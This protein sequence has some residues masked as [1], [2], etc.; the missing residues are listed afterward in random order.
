LPTKFATA[1]RAALKEFHMRSTQ[2]RTLTAM[3]GQSLHKHHL[4]TEKASS[5]DKQCL[6][7]LATEPRRLETAQETWFTRSEQ[8]KQLK[9]RLI[10]VVR[11][12]IRIFDCTTPAGPKLPATTTTV[13]GAAD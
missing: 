4:P 9:L 5:A 1:E 8:V 13:V 7:P 2:L 6:G 3:G 10:S 11:I 12:M